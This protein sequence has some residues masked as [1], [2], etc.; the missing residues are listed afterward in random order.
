MGSLRKAR[1][2]YYARLYYSNNGRN[3]EKIFPLNTSNRRQ[4]ESRLLEV[5]QFQDLAINGEFTPSWKSEN[6]NP[7]A[8]GYKLS[9]ATEDFLKSRKADNARNS[10]L[11]IYSRG[12]NLFIEAVTDKSVKDITIE[13]IDKFK[14]YYLYK[15]MPATINMALRPV[16]SLLFWL[17]E[18]D[19]INKVP[20]IKQINTGYSLPIYVTNAEFEEICKRVNPHFQRAF[21]FYRES[22]LR[23][24]EPFMGVLEGNFFKIKACDYKGNHDHEISLTPELKTIL[25]EMRSIVNEKVRAKI[26]T[27]ENAIHLYTSIFYKACKGDTRYGWNQI[28]NRKF[29]SLRHTCGIRSYIKTKDIYAVKKTLGHR[30]VTTTEIYTKYNEKRLQQDFPDLFKNEDEITKKLVEKTLSDTKHRTQQYPIFA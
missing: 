27:L 22:G 9:E 11:D 1:G 21:W 5:K 26:A 15:L 17:K 3:K 14:A 18:R 10:T 6:G 24:S 7:C 12:L 19:L 8:D 20:R 2:K 16:K 13:D 25:I 28:K 4:A 29:H 23:L 30:S